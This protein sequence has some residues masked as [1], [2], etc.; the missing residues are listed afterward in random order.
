MGLSASVCALTIR[1]CSCLPP[2][3]WG[4]VVRPRTP[5][6]Q[7]GAM[8]VRGLIV[9]RG[10]LCR[11]TPAF[12]SEWCGTGRPRHRSAA[13]PS[14]D[15]GGIL[16]GVTCA[17]SVLTD[18]LTARGACCQSARIRAVGRIRMVFTFPRQRGG[19]CEPGARSSCPVFIAGAACLDRSTAIETGRPP[20]SAVPHTGGRATRRHRRLVAT[21]APAHDRRVDPTTDRE[22]A[23]PTTPRPDGASDKP[24]GTPRPANGRRHGTRRAQH[25]A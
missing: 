13:T 17:V 14:I 1:V 24:A 25:T 10:P 16:T 18:V 7:R 19:L 20:G 2:G 11:V 6:C 9:H 21:G 22:V 12:L 15:I 8:V 23:M 5:L 3:P 4:F